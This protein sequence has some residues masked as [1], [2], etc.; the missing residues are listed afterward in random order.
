ML[1]LPF[2]LLLTLSLLSAADK[3]SLAYIHDELESQLSL[4][5]LVFPSE[6]RGIAIGV[7]VDKGRP[8]PL[9]LVTSD[10]G[11][12]WDTVFLKD[13]PQHIACF[14]DATCWIATEKGVWKSDE[15]GRTWQRVS[16]QKGILSLHFDSPTHGFAAGS[17]KSVWETKDAGA[18]WTLVPASREIEA[19]PKYAAFHA[20][21]FEGN[22]GLIIGTSRPPRRG[23][24]S[25]LPPWMD[26][27]G[28]VKQRE[29]PNLL[30]LI[31]TRDGGKTWKGFSASVFGRVTS[32]R[33]AAVGEALA[34][35]EYGDGFEFSAEVNRINL[36]DG[37]TTPFYRRKEH[38][39]TDML[40]RKTG[41]VLIAGTETSA[42]RSIPIPSKVLIGEVSR[43][44]DGGAGAFTQ[45]EMHYKAVAK[46]VSLAL[47]PEGQAWAV[48]DTGMILRLD[49]QR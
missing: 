10:G 43:R 1:R 15:S 7:L 2:I 34:L 36:R 32:L 22:L 42:L 24:N 49:R 30:L 12:R 23:D 31:E 46:R 18:K 21:G 29:I 41:D 20:I 33:V 47:S 6:R 5:Q 44:A 26:P 37:K 14:G 13:I 27:E 3:W 35:F 39:I 48:T 8:R 11:N 40:R 38:T 25:L 16:K 4:R 28:Q 45:H 9:A 19:N 17:E